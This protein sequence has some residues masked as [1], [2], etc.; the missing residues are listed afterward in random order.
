MF[1]WNRSYE[2]GIEEIDLQHQEL[3]RIGGTLQGHLNT[4]TDDN[5]S[6]RMLDCLENLAEYAVFHFDTEEALFKQYD[7]EDAEKHIREHRGFIRYLENIKVDRTDTETAV[8]ELLHFVSRW[9]ASHIH[10]SD[11][12]YVSTVANGMETEAAIS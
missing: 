9:I 3:F 12:S 1:K 4:C 10:D 2:T 6:D 8:T 5:L 7:Y 11:F